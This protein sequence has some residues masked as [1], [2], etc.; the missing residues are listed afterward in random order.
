[1][2][3][4]RKRKSLSKRRGTTATKPFHGCAAST[5]TD[6]PVRFTAPLFAEFALRAAFEMSEGKSMVNKK[7]LHAVV[8]LLIIGLGIVGRF[9]SDAQQPVRSD[10]PNPAAT[11]SARD[12]ATAGAR[13]NRG[14]AATPVLL[15]DGKIGG[16]TVV[17]NRTGE[18]IALGTVD[19]K[20]TLAR[21]AAGE[22]N[23]H[24]NDGSVYRNFNGKLPKKKT[25]YYREYVVPT[26]DIPG[27]GPQRVV[28]GEEGEI[29]YTSDHYETF[30]RVKGGG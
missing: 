28:L 4:T 16:V 11:P 6:V 17:N 2:V 13:P 8:V 21:I 30:I 25:G 1:M 10:P 7:H 20:P 29:Y 14:E 5:A 24:R 12:L 23:P 18:R 3:Q 27:P 22:K 26:P 9:L 15:G 19:L